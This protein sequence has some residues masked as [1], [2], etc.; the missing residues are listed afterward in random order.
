MYQPRCLAKRFL[1]GPSTAIVIHT[2]RKEIYA[3]VH[4]GVCVSVCVILKQSYIYC[5][6]YF[7]G[8][9]LKLRPSEVLSLRINSFGLYCLIITWSCLAAWLN[10]S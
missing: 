9:L 10:D 6:G 7:Y 5:R 4:S 8:T 1:F 3:P 2:G